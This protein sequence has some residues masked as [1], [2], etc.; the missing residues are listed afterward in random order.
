MAES[1]P[2]ELRRLTEVAQKLG[3][4]NEWAKLDRS[5]QK[6]GV[7]PSFQISNRAVEELRFQYEEWLRLRAK[8]QE[9]LATATTSTSKGQIKQWKQHMQE[10]KA[11]VRELNIDERFI[12]A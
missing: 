10:V 12:R 7:P 9:V 3:E 5:Q 1:I 6:P 4:L 8:L 11:Y 2:E